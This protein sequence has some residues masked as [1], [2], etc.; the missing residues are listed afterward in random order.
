MK[1]YVVTVDNVS[2]AEGVAEKMRALG[3]SVW[4]IYSTREETL[5]TIKTIVANDKVNWRKNGRAKGLL[6]LDGIIEHKAFWKKW[7]EDE[8]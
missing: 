7:N 6:P 2:Y 5:A 4:L 8:N 3:H 1:K